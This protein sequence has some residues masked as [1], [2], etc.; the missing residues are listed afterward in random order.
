M[1]FI[2]PP[3]FT[4]L[5]WSMVN[6][7]VNAQKHEAGLKMPALNPKSQLADLKGNHVA[8]CVPDYVGAIKWYTE[9]LDFRVIK[10]WQFADEN[11]AYLAP[12]NS[13]DFWIEILGEGKMQPTEIYNDLAKSLEKTGYHH[14]CMDVADV[15]CNRK[16]SSLFWDCYSIKPGSC[17]VLLIPRW[18]R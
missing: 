12:A 1:K 10:E 14:I 16:N 9:K 8:I 15:D 7:N 18:T 3:L 11:L 13:N 17:P 6:I 5:I 4:V 2:T